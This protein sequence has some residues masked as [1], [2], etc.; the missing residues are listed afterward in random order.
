MLFPIISQCGFQRPL[1]LIEQRGS[2]VVT[3]TVS[4][5]GNFNALEG[6]INVYRFGYLKMESCKHLWIEV[7]PIQYCVAVNVHAAIR[8][9]SQRQ[10]IAYLSNC[11]ANSLKYYCGKISFN[12]CCP[13]ICI[14]VCL[15]STHFESMAKYSFILMELNSKHLYC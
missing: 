1:I 14:Y 13:Y 4:G 2:V 9:R 5:T 15:H 7:K 10:N 6:I 3:V 12:R 11:L 8:Q